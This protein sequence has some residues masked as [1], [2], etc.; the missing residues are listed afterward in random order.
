MRTAHSVALAAAAVL[1]AGCVEMSQEIWINEDGSGRLVMDVGIGAEMLELAKQ[2]PAAGGKDPAA[3]MR[4]GF[5]E[6]KADLEKDPDVKSVQFKEFTKEGT[7][8]FVLD[9][10]VRK[11]ESLPRILKKS[12]PDKKALGGEEGP[13]AEP[14][15]K[16]EKTAGGYRFTQKFASPEKAAPET[17]EEKRNKAMAMA[18]LKPML[19]DKGIAVKL[20]APRILSSN[21]E[22][23]E[24]KQTAAWK[25]GLIEIATTDSFSKELTA[26]VHAGAAGGGKLWL[27]VAIA[28]VLV[29]LV[30]AVTVA[31]RGGAPKRPE[32]TQSV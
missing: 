11:V 28:A 27:V 21:G 26:E 3:D 5:E 16:I 30:V 14:E 24:D 6:R 12:S 32:P 4:K 7:C 19:Q 8:H 29:V 31:R 25:I 10:E 2:G 20:H 18:F 13:A 22:V 17:E 9:I 15:L 1:L 23:S